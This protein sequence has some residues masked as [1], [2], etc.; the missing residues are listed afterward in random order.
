MF[1][2]QI[3]DAFLVRTEPDSSMVNPAHIHITSA[4]QTRKENVL[5]TNAVSSSTPAAC[6]MAGRARKTARDA[7]PVAAR[8]AAGR[9]CER[10]LVSVINGYPPLDHVALGQ[11]RSPARWPAARL[12]HCNACLNRI[13]PGL[14]AC[15]NV[16]L[17][18]HSA[19]IV[20]PI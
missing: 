10:I 15:I 3:I 2:R 13:K 9:R 18:V 5:K 6:A 19:A 12:C 14:I 20:G 4:P 1:F 7:M 11:T 16:D 17:E 8:M